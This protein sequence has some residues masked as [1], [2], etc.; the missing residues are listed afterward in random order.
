MSELLLDYKYKPNATY[1]VNRVSVNALNPDINL[2]NSANIPTISSNANNTF[3]LTMSTDR[4]G[5]VK[6]GTTTILSEDYGKIDGTT[7]YK[8][9]STSTPGKLIFK[10]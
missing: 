1:T 9:D 4:T 10:I 7:Y 5:W 8:T 6:S 3:G 2:I